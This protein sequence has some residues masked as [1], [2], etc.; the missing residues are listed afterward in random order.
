MIVTTAART[1]ESNEIA[2]IKGQLHSVVRKRLA[3]L[4]K[5]PLVQIARFLDPTQQRSM[6]TASVNNTVIVL[7]DIVNDR[8]RA[9][10]FPNTMMT[11]WSHKLS[12]CNGWPADQLGATL[13]ASVN[14]AK[15]DALD[16]W[17]A[18]TSMLSPLDAVAR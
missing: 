17:R 2:E 7:I 6:T 15:T 8:F 5:I 4:A 3:K 9:V 10:H 14:L 11:L 13:D 18:N 16:W 1:G 12:A